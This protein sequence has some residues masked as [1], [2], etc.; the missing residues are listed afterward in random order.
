MIGPQQS[1]IQLFAVIV[2]NDHFLG[3]GRPDD[4]WSKR[5]LRDVEFG[6]G[7]RIVG[8]IVGKIAVNGVRLNRFRK[9]GEAVFEGGYAK[10]W[11]AAGSG[12]QHVQQEPKTGDQGDGRK[13]EDC[14]LMTRQADQFNIYCATGRCTP[15]TLDAPSNCKRIS[16]FRPVDAGSAKLT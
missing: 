1:H 5:V 11:P 13:C 16:G 2:H 15:G 7:A 10:C 12:S 4:G 3:D 9:I 6:Q 8:R 14:E